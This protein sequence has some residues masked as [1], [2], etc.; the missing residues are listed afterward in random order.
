MQVKYKDDKSIE[1]RIKRYFDDLKKIEIYKS[2]LKYFEEYKDVIMDDIREDVKHIKA[3]IASME[4][5]NKDVE[6]VLKNLSSEEKIYVESRYKDELSIVKVKEKL[7]MS[8]NT[9]Y[10]V[11]KN[12]I[13]KVRKLVL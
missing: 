13:E 4:F 10:K 9:Y 6:L 7:Y 2:K 12:V 1:S 3:T 5:K 8:K 11:R